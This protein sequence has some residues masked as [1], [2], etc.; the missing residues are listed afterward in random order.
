MSDGEYVYATIEL[1]TLHKGPSSG[2][3]NAIFEAEGMFTQAAEMVWVV[4]IDAMAKVR[5]IVPVAH[6]NEFEVT[7]DL[8]N[9]MQAVWAAGTKRFFLVHNHP[10]GNVSPTEAD[11]SL[12]KQ[13][14]MAAAISAALLEDH[15]ILGPPDQWYSMKDAGKFIPS[16]AIQRLYA[17][18]GPIRLHGKED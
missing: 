16:P 7:V 8:A 3:L 11:L 1:R 5:A 10:S 12:T 18:N 14:N 15:I 17:A 2:D 6:G 4:A 9:V 13:V